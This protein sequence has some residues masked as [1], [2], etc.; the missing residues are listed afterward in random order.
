[1]RRVLVLTADAGYGHRSAANAVAAALRELHGF[2]CTVEV[3]NPLD[4]DR[5]PLLLRTS[6]SDYDRLVREMPNLYEFGYQASDAPVPAA[7]VE[8]ALAV[9]LFEVTLDLVR[10]HQPDAI[11]TTYP[12]YQAPL[13]LVFAF[14]R[15]AIPLLTAVTDLVTVHRLWFNTAADLCLVPTGSVR[16]L[17]LQ[18]GLPPER[19]R[20][21]GIPVSPRLALASRDK[22]A[23]R[24][25]LGWQ[26]EP[27][28]LLVVGGRRVQGLREV[29]RALNHSGLPLQ[30][31]VVAGGDEALHQEL[32]RVDWHIPAHVYGFVQRL[33]EMML[34]ADCVA[35]KAGGLVV[36]EALAAGLPM[37]LVDTLPGQETG[38]A[39]HVIGGGAGERTESPVEV[40]EV[41]CHWLGRDGKLLT[42]H[43]RQARRLGRPRAA[44]DVAE[45]AWEA[46]GWDVTP[47]VKPPIVDLARLR[48]R[49]PQIAAPRRE[50]DTPD[51]DPR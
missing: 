18:S 6:Q 47:R 45:L 34:A 12:L 25:A 31:A 39:A 16:D 40:L 13:G 20:V 46:A 3:V 29:L 23:L 22:P 48:P 27:T 9:V 50:A 49:L 32:V 24:A 33:P 17:A 4:D 14:I 36:T 5:V 28:T 15:R 43:A 10:R 8:R 41:L 2:D 38:N 51:P 21:T 30:L 42:E 26:P 44:L 37:L 19:V 1:V 7:I 11:V 35:C